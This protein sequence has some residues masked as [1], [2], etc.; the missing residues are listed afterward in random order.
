VRSSENGRLTFDPSYYLTE[1]RKRRRR[2][3][4]R[5]ERGEGRREGVKME[6]KERGKNR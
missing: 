2:R 3:R 1:K 5:C 6:K 4:R